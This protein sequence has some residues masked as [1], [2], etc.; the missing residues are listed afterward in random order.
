MTLIV[1]GDDKALSLSTALSGGVERVGMVTAADSR[2]VAGA[3]RY[4]IRIVD[5]TAVQDGDGNHHTKF[6]ESGAVI[7]AI[8]HG[9]A[10]D[11]SGGK[12]QPGVVTAITDIG[13]SILSAPSAILGIPPQQ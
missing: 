7:K 2:A 5:L 4:N 1:S 11:G 8:G 13:E 6:A 12:A 9:L 3:A 10:T